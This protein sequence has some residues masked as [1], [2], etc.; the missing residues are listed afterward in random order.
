MVRMLSTLILEL[1]M[2]RST[3]FQGKPL[4]L[5]GQELKVGQKLPTFK[6]TANDMSDATNSDFAGKKLIIVTVPSLDTSVCSMESKKFNDQAASLGSDV[7]VLVIS[8]DLPFAQK[9]WC[10]AEGVEN[11]KTFSDYKYRNV[12][13]NFGVLIEDWQLLSRAIFV[14]NAD[15]IIEYLEYVPEIVAEPDYQ[16]VWKAI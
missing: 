11:I 4:T 15:G 5:L 14:A 2:A 3:N 12:A 7:L 13:E 6:I 9:R 1:T 16:A 8:R 10:G